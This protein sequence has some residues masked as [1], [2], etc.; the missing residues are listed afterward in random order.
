MCLTE[1]DEEEARRV[2]HE[3]GY[4]EG[5]TE[6]RSEKAVEAALI[7]IKDF[8]AEPEIAAKKMNAPLEKVLEA[9]KAQK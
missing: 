8:N 7:L 9:I 6:G 4:T 5:L 1:F 3:D 2:W